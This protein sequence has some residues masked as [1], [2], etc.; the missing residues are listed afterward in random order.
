LEWCVLVVIKSMLLCVVVIS[1][2]IEQSRFL[3]D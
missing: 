1:F 2:L 3:T